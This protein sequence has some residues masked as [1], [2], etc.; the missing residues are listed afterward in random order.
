M[1]ERHVARQ[2]TAYCH[3]ELTAAEFSRVQQHLEVCEPCRREYD[4]IRATVDLASQLGLRAGPRASDIAWSTSRRGTTSLGAL[5]PHRGSITAHQC[6]GSGLVPLAAESTFLGGSPP[7]RQA[8][9]G[10]ERHW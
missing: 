10:M 9:G 1:L 6:P 7:R 3:Q 4:N 5:G 2:L 8:Q